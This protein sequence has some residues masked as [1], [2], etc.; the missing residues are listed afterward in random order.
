MQLR[1]RRAWAFERLLAGPTTAVRATAVGAYVAA[2]LLTLAGALRLSSPGTLSYIASLDAEWG[3]TGYL[4]MHLVGTQGA[5][6]GARAA[7]AAWMLGVLVLA[8]RRRVLP[9]GVLALTPVPVVL[10]LTVLGPLLAGAI[11]D[12]VL[13]SILWLVIMAT[14]FLGVP[15]WCAVVASLVLARRRR[16]MP[17]PTGEPVTRE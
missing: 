3:R 1:R 14:F 2:S 12:G 15:V 16:A 6:A 4:V 13:G 8:V 9:G 7:I 17:E 10:L 5:T 11:E